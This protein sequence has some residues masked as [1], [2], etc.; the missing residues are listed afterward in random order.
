MDNRQMRLSPEELLKISV[1]EMTPEQLFQLFDRNQLIGV[2]NE[3]Q[4]RLENWLKIKSAR[5][6][7]Q[8][9]NYA[10]LIAGQ[11]AERA[12]IALEIRLAEDAVS[13]ATKMA[14]QNSI[15][16]KE[17]RALTKYTKGLY[18]LTAALVV[19]AIIQIVIMARDS[20]VKWKEEQ[21]SVYTTENVITPAPVLD[22][23]I[24]KPQ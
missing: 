19:S 18:W 9:Y 3:I 14:E 2:P 11:W 23:P 16:V 7:E 20:Y 10:N 15:L 1:E 13:T 6:L 5:E 24:T 21:D 22:L 17:S 12:K 4:L 8:F